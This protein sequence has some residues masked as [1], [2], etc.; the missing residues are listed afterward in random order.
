MALLSFY[1]HSFQSHTLMIHVARKKNICQVF[2]TRKS[3][4]KIKFKKYQHAVFE[5]LGLV[6]TFVALAVTVFFHKVLFW[7]CRVKIKST[8]KNREQTLIFSICSIFLTFLQFEPANRLCLRLIN[9]ECFS[10]KLFIR[11][12]GHNFFQVRY[13]ILQAT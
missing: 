3:A 10:N 13:T 8:W 12:Q 6:Y 5:P 2:M 9:Y 11:V 4:L 1:V 7:F